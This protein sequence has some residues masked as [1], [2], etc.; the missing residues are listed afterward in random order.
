MNLTGLISSSYGRLTAEH[1]G[2]GRQSVGLP[3]WTDRFAITTPT[4]IA[5]VCDPL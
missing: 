1:F 5:C 4:L 2:G 3:D